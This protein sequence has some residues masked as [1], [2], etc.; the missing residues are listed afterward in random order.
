M[1]TNFSVVVKPS[2]IAFFDALL[3]YGESVHVGQA[4]VEHNDM[5][6]K[7]LRFRQC[8]RTIHSLTNDSE[9]G[10]GSQQAANNSSHPVVIIY[11]QD[12]DAWILG[13]ASMGRDSTSPSTDWNIGQRTVEAG[14]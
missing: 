7:F 12:T 2:L 5:G 8:F 11:N 6:L 13:E 10:L 14:S 4:D 1:P 3:S 9:I